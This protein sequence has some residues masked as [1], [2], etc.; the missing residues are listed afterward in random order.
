M[1]SKL[2]QL[3]RLL[4]DGL[5][6]DAG[7][8]QRHGYSRS[9]VAKYLKG[10]WLEAPVREAYRRPG[11]ADRETLPSATTVILS[12][13][14]LRPPLLAVGGRTALELQGLA[15]YAAATGPAEYHLYG[16]APPPLWARRLLGAQL[17]YHRLGLFT[18]DPLLN[19]DPQAGGFD[20]HFTHPVGA[21]SAAQLIV[22]T[23]E[24]AFLELLDTVPQ[25]ASF[26]EADVLMQG[27]G[28]LSPRRLY[29]LL[30]D[31]R[32]VKV[33]RLALWFA[34]RHAHAWAARLERGAL[35]LGSGKRVL[36]PGG[37]LDPTYNIT[38]P[39]DMEAP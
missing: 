28:S 8:L 36:V 11:D 18:A 32:S 7:W 1:D 33:K 25:V 15:H 37:R 30:A 12:L 23:P 9:L 26:H 31:C 38:V 39:R 13:Q 4:P 10:G 21:G 27:L 2:N 22:S 5:L 14:R 3:Q 35:D 24:R 17:V 34:D 19:Q 29:A 16:A 20:R 6:V